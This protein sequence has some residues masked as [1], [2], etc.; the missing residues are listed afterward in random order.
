MKEIAIYGTGFL[1]KKIYNELLE[2]GVEISYFVRSEHEDAEKFNN[3]FVMRPEELYKKNSGTIVIIAIKNEDVLKQ[4]YNT[5][6]NIGF[7]RNQVIKLNETIYSYILD[8]IIVSRQKY[9]GGRLCLC[10]NSNVKNFLPYNSVKSELF[11]IHEIIGG[12]NRENAIC[13]ICG[14]IDRNRWQT[15]VLTKYTDILTSKCNVLHIAPELSLRTLITDNNSCDYYAGDIVLTRNNHMVDLTK[16][17]FENL[18]FDYIIANHVLEHIEDIEIAFS[19]IKRVLKDTGKLIISFP[20]CME[21]KTKEN[22]NITE[23]V[24]RLREFGQEDHVRLFGYDYKEY[25]EQY[26]FDVIVKSPKDCLS[27]EEIDKYGMISNDVILI[28]KKV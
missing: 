15:Y 1:G 10:C 4:I 11:K 24:E 7:K 14:S 23:P 28:C 3:I 22:R 18:F 9:G 25:I 2:L 8:N 13:P 12:G 5:L 19:E 27:N 20:I 17:Q 21:I 26:G 16:I 6:L